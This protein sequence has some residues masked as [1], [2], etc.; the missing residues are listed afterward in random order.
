MKLEIKKINKKDAEMCFQLDSDTISLWSRNQW[1]EE[2]IK[3]DVYVFGIL[4]SKNIIGICLF[5]KIIDEAQINYFSVNQKFR[6]LGLGT[7]LMKFILKECEIL[8]IRKLLLEV[9]KNN[10]V[11]EDFY[12]KFNF[13]T[14]GVRKKY[15]QDGSD[16]LLKEKYL[17]KNP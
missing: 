13:L 3:D 7:Y 2:L 1:E 4:S 8:K 14:V 15:Y 12:N 11:A 6:R 10:L 17:L 16:A 5:Q 9:S